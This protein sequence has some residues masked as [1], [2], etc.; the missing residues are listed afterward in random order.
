MGE[1]TRLDLPYPELPD[2]ADV[3]ADMLALAQA[4]DDTAVV[5]QGILANRPASA[6]EGFF[7]YATDDGHLYYDTGSTWL[8][9]TPTVPVDGAANVASLRTLGAGAQQAAPGNDARFARDSV[10]VFRSAPVDIAKSVNQLIVW[11]AEGHDPSGMHPANS[12]GI[13][14]SKPGLWEVKV[15]VWWQSVNNE[16]YSREL[17]L[18]N[19]QGVLLAEVGQKAGTG[20]LEQQISALVGMHPADH[21]RLVTISATGLQTGP[22]SGE[23][24][25]AG[26]YLMATYLGALA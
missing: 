1:T 4:L 12:Y 3:P 25:L 18:Y 14:L 6:L 8:D 2:P 26:S 23:L 16:G 9:T 7:Y 17:K 15:N 20:R 19:D 22:G 13:A 5:S 10:F 24:I 11:N 21:G